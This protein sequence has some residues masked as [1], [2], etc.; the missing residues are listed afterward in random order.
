[1]TNLARHRIRLLQIEQEANRKNGHPPHHRTYCSLYHLSAPRG[2]CWFFMVGFYSLFRSDAPLAFANASYQT[3]QRPFTAYLFPLS[4]HV[5]RPAHHASSCI[6]RP[7][8]HQAFKS[9]LSSAAISPPNGKEHLAFVHA[10][11][12]TRLVPGPAAVGPGVPALEF[13]VSFVRIDHRQCN[14]FA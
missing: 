11:R 12:V 13:S 14:G 9:R 6:M 3:A 5:K 2:F 8:L 10:N 1:M 7:P 4:A